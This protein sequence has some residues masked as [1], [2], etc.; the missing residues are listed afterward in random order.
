MHEVLLKA[1]VPEVTALPSLIVVL[2]ERLVD[3]GCEAV[4]R[5]S[6]VVANCRNALVKASLYAHFPATG[7][8]AIELEG[9]LMVKVEGED[10]GEVVRLVEI[11]SRALEGAGAGVTL[12]G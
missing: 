8:P 7:R 11:V 2:S 1:Y 3:I 10:L 4:R 5:P 6:W 9:S 12:Q